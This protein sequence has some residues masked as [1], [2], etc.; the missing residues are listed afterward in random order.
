MEPRKMAGWCFILFGVIHLLH[1]VHLQATTGRGITTLYA[2]ITSLLFTL[3]AA[4]L[5][6][7]KKGRSSS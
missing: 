7:N 4:F 5:W 1:A 3:G 6:L 2:L